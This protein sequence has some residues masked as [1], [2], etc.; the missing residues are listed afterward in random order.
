MPGQAKAGQEE[1]R[2]FERN[3]L[4]DYSVT[5]AEESSPSGTRVLTAPKFQEPEKSR[6]EEMNLIEQDEGRASKLRAMPKSLRHASGSPNRKKRT[7]DGARRDAVRTLSWLV[8]PAAALVLFALPMFPA[9]PADKDATVGIVAS[10]VGVHAAFAGL[11][12]VAFVFFLQTVV[13]SRRRRTVMLAMARRAGIFEAT[14]CSFGTLLGEVI[15]LVMCRT[16]TT[17]TVPVLWAVCLGV[18]VTILFT[19]YVLSELCT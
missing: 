6:V 2:L 3:R 18:A 13:Y 15:V 12:V 8:L 5:R 11:A 7:S 1:S 4:T 14:A 16:F 10:L 17:L 9:T 19:L